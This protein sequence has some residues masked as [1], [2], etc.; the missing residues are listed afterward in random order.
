MEKLFQNE[1]SG[2][3]IE[4]VKEKNPDGNRRAESIFKKARIE[5]GTKE[6]PAWRVGL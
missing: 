6:R 1:Y 2:G 5:E 3:S 4:Q